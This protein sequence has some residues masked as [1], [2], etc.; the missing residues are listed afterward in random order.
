MNI[1]LANKLTSMIRANRLGESSLQRLGLGAPAQDKGILSRVLGR[2][3]PTEHPTITSIKNAPN[4]FRDL[5]KSKEP[6]VDEF[7]RQLIPVPEYALAIP[8]FVKGSKGVG[9]G[10]IK[11]IKKILNATKARQDVMG[12]KETLKTPAQGA[13]SPTVMEAV[14][15]EVNVRRT[16][17]DHPMHGLP[18]VIEKLQQTDGGLAARAMGLFV[19]RKAWGGK[20]IN[21]A[22]EG[23]APWTQFSHN[24]LQDITKIPDIAGIR[25]SPAFKKLPAP[26]Q[27]EIVDAL[28]ALSKHELMHRKSALQNPELITGK[29]RM[30]DRLLRPTIE[31]GASNSSLNGIL[32]GMKQKAARM[33]AG[34]EAIGQFMA[35]QGKSRASQAAIRFPIDKLKSSNPELYD[36]WK[37]SLAH[38]PPNMQDRLLATRSHLFYNYGV[39]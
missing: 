4:Q 10:R 20:E 18:R 39:Q 17:P 12:F 27:G 2:K 37:A 15:K 35:T 6:V 24:F 30:L 31:T 7:M 29:I 1:K 14:L 25:N 28:L 23:K 38:L 9:L 36:K 22:F 32:K 33:P 26:Q 34:A 5:G 11:E 19:G 13:I 3:T 21:Q 8:D 16:N